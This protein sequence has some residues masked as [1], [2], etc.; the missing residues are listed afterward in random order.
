MNILTKIARSINPPSLPLPSPSRPDRLLPPSLL[1]PSRSFLSLGAR[2]GAHEAGAALRRPSRKS[3][4]PRAH[5][6][7]ARPGCQ[8]PFGRSNA[9][10]L[11]VKPF[12][13]GLPAPRDDRA[14]AQLS[15]R[16]SE[17]EGACASRHSPPP[18]SVTSPQSVGCQV[19]VCVF[20]SSSH[21]SRYSPPRLVRVV[22]GGVVVKGPR[23]AN[24]Q[25]GGPGS[26]PRPRTR[27]PR[28]LGTFLRLPSQ[29]AW[30]N[31]GAAPPPR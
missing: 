10:N 30:D 22:H 21:L 15:P 2:Q 1:A 13:S 28:P 14:R 29:L 25:D 8:A 19:L 3:S 4:T 20:R 9:P 16:A 24:S 26:A 27:P 12:P 31:G 6:A 5:S 7:H 17:E 18:R 23:A 11:P